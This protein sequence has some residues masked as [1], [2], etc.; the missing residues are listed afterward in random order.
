MARFIIIQELG[1]VLELMFETTE[2]FLLCHCDNPK[3]WCQNHQY[4]LADIII[5]SLSLSTGDPVQLH[6]T[7]KQY[8]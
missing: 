1:D 6:V 4:Q 3:G 2:M 5:I 8:T 7:K